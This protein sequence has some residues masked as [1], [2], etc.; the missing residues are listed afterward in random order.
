MEKTIEQLL[1][2]NACPHT[3][4]IFQQFLAKKWMAQLSYLPPPHYFAFPKLKL[5]LKGDRYALIEDIQK[6]VNHEIKSV[7]NLWVYAS[8]VMVRRWRQRVYSSVRRLFWIN[9]TFKFFFT[10]FAAL[11]QNLPDTPCTRDIQKVMYVH[12][13]HE[14]L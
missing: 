3:A 6:S 5:E 13:I 14:T 4:T 8:Y 10:V 11:L 1:Q 7:P 9:I 2:D 12:V